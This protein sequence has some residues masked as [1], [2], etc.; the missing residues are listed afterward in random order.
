MAARVVAARARQRERGQL[1]RIM[2]RRALDEVPWSRGA[3]QL[4]DRALDRH[5]L[6]GRGFDRV[7][8]VARTVAD[9][10]ACDEV[11]LEHVAEALAYRGDW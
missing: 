10:D 3:L 4:L 7:R 9:L 8:R 5:E 1:N 2:G 11:G 6:T